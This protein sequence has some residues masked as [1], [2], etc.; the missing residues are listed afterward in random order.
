[1]DHAGTWHACLAAAALAA[2]EARA[3]SVAFGPPL[4]LPPATP[5]AQAALAP[6]T[7]PP[8]LDLFVVEPRPSTPS[9]AWLYRRG[10]LAE[11]AFPWVGPLTPATCFAAGSW[12]GPG[13]SAAP[14]DGLA[15]L[16]WCG[17]AELRYQL[18]ANLADPFGAVSLDP[19]DPKPTGLAFARLLD[20]A[21]L[22]L[23]VG[24]RREIE[25]A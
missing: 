1:M 9:S 7:A 5:P 4:A 17:A 3:Q 15:D 19:A 21:D 2:G 13:L 24:E 8:A 6:W 11:V 20:R 23:A 10:D 14:G 16:G 18:S 12:V 25:I 22:V